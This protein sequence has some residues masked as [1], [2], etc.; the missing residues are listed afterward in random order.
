VSHKRP[1]DAWALEIQLA[2]EE[3]RSAELIIENRGLK[4]RVAELEA[5]LAGERYQRHLGRAAQVVRGSSGDVLGYTLDA[6]GFDDV[7]VGPDGAL[8]GRPSAPPAATSQQIA[9]ATTPAPAPA[10][11]GF[12]SALDRPPIGNGFE[13]VDS[14]AQKL[15]QPKSEPTRFTF[16]E[17][18]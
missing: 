10:S 6:P 12:S 7:Y 3:Q 14:T 5:A 11:K 1:P 16:L 18:D 8:H 2:K 17:V 13:G 9:S 4:T 15:Q